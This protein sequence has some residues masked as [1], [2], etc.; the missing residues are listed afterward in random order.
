MPPTLMA[1]PN[2]S[3]GRDPATIAAIA[4]AL[5]APHGPDGRRG[6]RLLDVHADASHHRSVYTLAGAPAELVDS[7]LAGACVAL[8]LIDV[9]EERMNLSEPAQHPHVGALDVAPIVYLDERDRGAACAAALVLADR[10]ASELA[11]PVFLYGELTGEADS[12][13]RTRAELRRGGLA[14]LAERMGG[15]ARAEPPPA[16]DPAPPAEPLRPDFGPRQPHPSAGAALVAARPPLVAFNVQLAPPATIVDARAIAVRIR[17][18]GSI[19]IAG[20]RAIGID[21]AGVPQV[22]MNIERPSE[23]PLADIVREI[24]GLAPVAGAELVGLAP[25]AALEAFPDDVPMPGFDPARH[26]IENALGG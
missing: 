4:A 21:L 8:D 23:T 11:V 13:P 22:S 2:F 18:G 1:V 7:L 3:E 25:A 24:S 14:G 26:V 15:E 5:A 16:A 10:L 6:A 20:V 9:G 19:G 12:P 17:E